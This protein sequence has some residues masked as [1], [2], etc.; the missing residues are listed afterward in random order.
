MLEELKTAIIIFNQEEL[1]KL[2]NDLASGQFEQ[3]FKLDIISNTMQ[4]AITANNPVAARSIFLAAWGLPRNDVVN[5]LLLSFEESESARNL[6][7]KDLLQYVAEIPYPY[8]SS[9]FEKF[10]IPEQ[11]GLVDPITRVIMNFPVKLV[12]ENDIVDTYDF[13]TLDL[14]DLKY[15]GGRLNPF[16]RKKF[17]LA[18]IEPDREA[19]EKIQKKI[20][21]SQENHKLLMRGVCKAA[22]DGDITQLKKLFE[23]NTNIRINS[24]FTNGYTPLHYAC[25]YQ[26]YDMA[27]YL[28]EQGADFEVKSEDS[29]TPYILIEKSNP[30]MAKRLREHLVDFLQNKNTSQ[31]AVN[32]FRYGKILL[33]GVLIKRDIDAAINHLERAGC[34][35]CEEGYLLAGD[36]YA[37]SIFGML[38]NLDKAEE[39]FNKAVVKYNSMASKI[40]LAILLLKNNKTE[41]LPSLQLT[42]EDVAHAARNFDP[43]ATFLYSLLFISNNEDVSYNEKRH[44]K[45]LKYAVQRGSLLASLLYISYCTEG[46]FVNKNLVEARRISKLASDTGCVEAQYNYALFCD[47]G[48]GGIKDQV[49]AA[50]YFKMAADCG[51]AKAQS[52]YARCCTNGLGVTKNAVEAAKYYKK[53]ADNGDVYGQFNYALCCND[54]VGIARNQ[55]KA[56]EYFKKAAENGH[57]EAQRNYAVCCH[58][59]LGVR[60]NL[61][62]AA[63]YYKM[64]ADNGFLI[65]QLNYGICCEEGLGKAVNLV[66]AARYYKI[67]ADNGLAPAQFAY[68]SMCLEGSGVR[69]DREEAA[70]YFKMAA[71]NGIEEAKH[72]YSLLMR[73]SSYPKF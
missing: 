50:L 13:D 15:D 54:G 22:K 67:A 73:A 21:E 37:N 42:P 32:C 35:G 71:D 39:F 12:R 47:E 53:A 62:E 19:Y 9:Q 29:I 11:E 10:S 49:Q 18:D 4:V 5:K 57:A 65:A 31:E 61:V 14:L 66:E 52:S 63:R 30:D 3:E 60:V 58:Q 46:K 34:L 23:E 8:N 51:L 70:R 69:M 41:S 24:E 48:L 26:Q 16:N 33:N 56:T 6:I 2:L 72:N 55:E 25:K 40:K 36:I 59:G 68:A 28:L 1:K 43:D 20:T 7:Y 64:S 38:K 27:V 44:I 17:T 45:Y